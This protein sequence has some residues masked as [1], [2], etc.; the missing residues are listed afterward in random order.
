M[1]RIFSDSTSD[2]SPELVER[3]QIHILPLNVN[4]DEE[5]YIDGK[6]ITPEEIY[7]WSDQTKKTPKTSVFPVSSAVSAFKPFILAGD[8][9]ICFAI[10]ESMSASA[11]VMRM[12]AKELHAEDRIHVVDSANLSTGIA[13]LVLTAADLIAQGADMEEILR[14]VEAKKPLVRSSFVVDTLTFLHRGGRCSGAAA[15][16]GNILKLH[17][18][19]MVRNG[20]MEVGKKYH[21]GIYNVLKHYEKDLEPDLLNAEPRRV[22]ITHSGCKAEWVDELRASLASL[23]Y[24][25]E[26]LETRAGCVVSSHCG[27]NTLGILYIEKEHPAVQ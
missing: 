17:P 13:L 8:E 20:K 22:F 7:V 26:I 3:Y 4:L 9:L 6:T 23:N 12:A 18:T 16:V 24:F 11:Q 2:L 1:I 14:V 27:P 15:L 21:S 10:S 5:T 25:D 19:I